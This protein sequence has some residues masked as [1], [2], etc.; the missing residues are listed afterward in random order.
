MRCCFWVS[1]CAANELK[2][3]GD[4][5]TPAKSFSLPMYLTTDSV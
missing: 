5:A 1:S 2:L 3:A 4:T